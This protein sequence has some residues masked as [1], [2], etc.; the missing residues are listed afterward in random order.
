[1]SLKFKEYDI[2]PEQWVILRELSI[3]DN[4]SQNE[5]SFKVEKDKNTIKA[6]VDK[7]EKKEYLIRQEKPNDKRVF[8]LGLTDKAHILIEKLKYID[9]EFNKDLSKN[10][11]E[12]DLEIFKSL[13]IKLKENL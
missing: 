10:L 5:L 13:L 2:T 9:L 3:K 7:L 12:K 4:I 8:L 11:D 6:I 1:M